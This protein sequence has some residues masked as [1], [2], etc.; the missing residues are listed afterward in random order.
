[1]SFD[2]DWN[3][4]MNTPMG[5]QEGTLTFDTSGDGLSGKMAGPQGTETFS[6]GSIDGN[7][8][9]WELKM[10]SPMPINLEFKVQ[11]NGEDLN[12]TVQLG[13]FGEAT[14]SGSKA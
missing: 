13:A 14:I 3:V 4:T 5:T 2:G 6:G 8:L 12:G 10:T 1:M 11:I 9:A 7:T